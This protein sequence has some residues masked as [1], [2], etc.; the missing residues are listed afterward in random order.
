MTRASSATVRLTRRVPGLSAIAIWA[1]LIALAIFVVLP[2]YMV[3]TTSF[4]PREDILGTE[5][6][7][8]V[9][10]A[11]L[12]NYEEVLTTTGL[13]RSIVNSTIV[14]VSVALF[15]VLISAMAGYA[16]AKFQFRGRRFLFLLVL[17]TL[18]VPAVVTVIPNFI[19]LARIG[20]IGSLAS[21]ILPALATPFGVYWMRQYISAA[22]HDELIEAARV[23]GASEVGI[24]AAIV[25]PISRP[26]LA[27]LAIW[28][29]ILSWNA[30]LLPLA[31]LQSND[32]FTYPVFFAGLMGFVISAPTH[33]LVAGSVLATLPVVVVFLLFQRQFVAGITSGAVKG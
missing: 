9:H 7:L 15:G 8:F 25:L 20:I 18:T 27:G 6:T 22:V 29:F 13:G 32:A 24:F 26:G 33:L 14:A 12:A 3:V 11:S 4:L 5:Q 28:L 19:L 10:D 23:D 16:F 30:L 21:V 1:G 17:A 2:L 31:Y